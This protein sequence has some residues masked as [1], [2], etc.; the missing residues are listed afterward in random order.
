LGQPDR[1]FQAQGEIVWVQ[2]EASIL[3][4]NYLTYP[5]KPTRNDF[6]TT[7]MYA[8][9][10]A[11]TNYEASLTHEGQEANFLAAVASLSVNGVATLIPVVQTKNILN[12]VAMGITGIDTAYNEKI[13]L[14]QTMQHVQTAMRTARYEQAAIILSN[15]QCEVDV[16]PI[17]LA[18]S[19]LE[20]YYRAGTLTTGL[21]KVTENVRDANETAKATKDSKAPSPSRAAIAKLAANATEARVKADNA[22]ANKCVSVGSGQRSFTPRL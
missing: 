13:L 15:M 7:R 5:S 8:I 12:Q 14:Q 4:N 16:Y 20:L 3:F 17:G 6:I 2:N 1:A 19:D 21:M 9:D 10:I 11:Y 22:V 18:L